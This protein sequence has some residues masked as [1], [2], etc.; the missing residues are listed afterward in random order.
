MSR[1]LGCRTG[2]KGK[3]IFRAHGG[4]IRYKAIASLRIEEY[5][6][7]CLRRLQLTA[8]SLYIDLNELDSDQYLLIRNYKVGSY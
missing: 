6:R 2:C 3:P 8:S 1:A 7:I 4:C 5:I